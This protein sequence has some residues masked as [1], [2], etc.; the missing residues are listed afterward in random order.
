MLKSYNIPASMASS[1][2]RPEIVNAV[3]SG[4]C[5]KR[6]RLALPEP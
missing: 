1:S 4:N 3:R 2:S 5:E 6:R